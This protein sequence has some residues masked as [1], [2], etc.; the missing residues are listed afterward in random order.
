[1]SKDQTLK[2]IRTLPYAQ[3]KLQDGKNIFYISLF[4]CNALHD[5]NK[6]S[7]IFISH[8]SFFQDGTQEAIL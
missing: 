7:Q 1:M 2:K 4:S 5:W 8:H 6:R 3:E